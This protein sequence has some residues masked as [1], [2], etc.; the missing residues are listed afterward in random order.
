MS[1]PELDTTIGHAG[2][3]DFRTSKPVKVTLSAKSLED[4]VDGAV[5]A[6]LNARAKGLGLAPLS[7]TRS[8]SDNGGTLLS[9]LAEDHQQAELE[10]WAARFALEPGEAEYH[11]AYGLPADYPTKPGTVYHSGKVTIDGS[12]FVI[13]VWCVADRD[14]WDQYWAERTERRRGGA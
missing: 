8:S 14:A 6:Y 3:V 12:D 10:A 11:R 13:R 5:G 7:W 1:A 9:G 2:T 4:A